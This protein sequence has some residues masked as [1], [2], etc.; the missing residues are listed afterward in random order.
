MW[1]LLLL[2]QGLYLLELLAV[3]S[4]NKGLLESIRWV[5]VSRELCRL[6]LLCPARVV[7]LIWL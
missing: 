4:G 3:L 2:L 1:L 6:L 5:V 7:V